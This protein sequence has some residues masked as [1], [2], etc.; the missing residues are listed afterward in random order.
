RHDKTKEFIYSKASDAQLFNCSDW[1]IGYTTVA[2]IDPRSCNEQV[3][4][5][6]SKYMT[7]CSP[8]PPGC[9]RYFKSNNLDSRQTL[10]KYTDDINKVIERLNLKPFKQSDK[11]IYFSDYS[12]LSVDLD[13]SSL[14]VSQN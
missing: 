9:K 12:N 2:C 11:C 10:V 7:K 4:N 8:A 3:V 1:K 13:L 5:Y 14:K 6:M